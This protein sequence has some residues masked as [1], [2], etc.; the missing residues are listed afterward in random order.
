MEQAFKLSYLQSKK[1]SKKNKDFIFAYNVEELKKGEEDEIEEEVAVVFKDSQKTSLVDRELILRRLKR[2]VENRT[3]GV[4][5][6]KK[7][8]VAFEDEDDID[9]LQLKKEAE[10]AVIEDKLEEI[11][12]ENDEVMRE[13]DEVVR[14][15]VSKIEEEQVNPVK[16]P[17]KSKAKKGPADKDIDHQV[18]F[19]LTVERIGKLTAI[20]RLPVRQRLSVGVSSYYM[21]NRKMYTSQLGRLFK[22][23]SDK[24][25]AKSADITCATLQNS[26]VDFDLLTH[27]LVIRD[28]LNLYTPYRGL[29]LYHGLGSGKTCTSIGVAEGMKSGKQIVLMTPASLKMNF[30][31]ELKKCGDV[32]Y[33]KN[34]F[35]E[36]ISIEGDTKMLRILSQSLGLDPEYIRSKG[37]AWMVNIKKRS[38]FAILSDAN[39]K[40]VDQQLDAMI[41]NKY[42]DINYNGLRLSH[43]D[44]MTKGG[45]VNPFDNKVVII[46]EAHNL[47]SR[48]ANTGSKKDTIAYRLYHDLMDATNVKIVFL[49]GTPIIN[50]PREIGILFNMLRGYIKTWTFT[51]QST[52]TDKVNTEIIM[53]YL[54]E[55]GLVTYD[56][57]DYSSGKLTVTRNPFGF[58]NVYERPEKKDR[59]RKGG[60]AT[61]RVSSKKT[62]RKTKKRELIPNNEIYNDDEDGVLIEELDE[63][64]EIDKMYRDLEK[65]HYE[66]GSGATVSGT[67]PLYG[68]GGGAYDEYSGVRLDEM[69]N[70]S[71]AEFQKRIV[72]ILGDHGLR[73]IGKSTI[74]KETCL[75]DTEDLFNEYF[76][77]GEK[78]ELIQSPLFK[79][80]ILGLTSYFRSAQEQLLP[81]FVK[82]EDGS[83]YHIINVEMSD[84]QFEHYETVRKEERDEESKKRKKKR[85]INDEEEKQPSTYRIY[86]R[87]ACNFAFP[88]EYPRPILTGK[89]KDFDAFNAVT[90]EMKK[91]QDD[92]FEEDEEIVEKP[93]VKTK[94]KKKEKEVIDD[95]GDIDAIDKD[96][97]K[98]GD[99]EGGGA[100]YSGVEDDVF[101]PEE[102]VDYEKRILDTY[103]FLAYNPKRTREKEYLR[104]RDLSTYSPKFLAILHNIM[105]EENRGLH[106]LYSQFRT[107]E[108]IGIFKLIL[109]ANGF[110]EFKLVKKGREWEIENWDVDPEKPRFVLYTG[111][112]SA[113]EK[114]IVRNIY[115]GTWDIVPPSIVEELRKRNMNNLYGEIIKVMMITASG[116][117]GINLR[118][119][120]F[121]HIVE[122]YWN[123]VRVDQVVGRARRICS[124]EDLPEDMRN[125]KVMIYLCRATKSQ[126]DKNIEL[127]TKDLSKLAYKVSATKSERIPFTTDQYLF[128]IAQIK[129]SITKQILTAVKE[130]A[131]DCSLYNSS[132]DEPL[133]CYGFGQVEKQ[134]FASYPMLERDA[135]EK[136]VDRK[137]QVKLV[138][139][140]VDEVKY[141]ANKS[142]MVVYDYQSYLNAKAKKGQLMRIGVYD[143]RT[144]TILFD[145]V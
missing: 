112:E 38:N 127:R 55:D 111:T 22:K 2:P 132:S 8:R 57:L 134:S 75:P 83:N 16:K 26:A 1:E 104:E 41:R 142:T 80:R 13:D 56:Y 87:S 126:I 62:N 29:L 48:I 3:I 106:L 25:A 130:T 82:D 99:Q 128:E 11:I 63:D 14:E 102:S 110:M 31:N 21:N 6:P 72:R 96:W 93:Q 61:K 23:Y 129:D 105:N 33:K 114:D 19:D 58:V 30:F 4:E 121:V 107:L 64:V 136:E 18:Q 68:V 135:Q 66:G 36:F 89:K 125:V 49:S 34:Q 94:Q 46:D 85:V 137:A 81:S 90:K 124:H 145:K 116:A 17:K 53:D 79:R 108:G 54:R 118:N 10:D 100:A 115:N 143:E 9:D 5:A 59:K 84:H 113:E 45:K 97:D 39:Q 40:A 120:R 69:G 47:V 123:M 138:A 144:K 117:E 92:Y 44:D 76:I 20:E 73:V 67:P 12:K 28:Y 65:D 88:P 27:Q 101:G 122:P 43:L 24:I 133:V 77:N 139:L 15:D 74:K 37:G 98:E 60:K 109:E 119:T 32:L 50:T 91:A 51:L 86:S 7:K 78:G 42:I 70:M 131:I 140:T 141:A 52:T 95:I 103:D 35:W 71:D